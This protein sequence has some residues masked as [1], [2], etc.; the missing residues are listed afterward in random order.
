MLAL[1][2][3]LAA[4]WMTPGYASNSSM[5]NALPQAAPGLELYN[6]KV[7]HGKRLTAG[8]RT[9]GYTLYVP[10]PVGNLKGG[11]YPLAVLIH[12]FLMTGAQQSNNA[13]GLAQR[14]FVVL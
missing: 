13:Q 10:E 4:S 11:P 2:I 8:G 7:T 6:V 14:G 1:A 9:R 12:G 3:A 5:L